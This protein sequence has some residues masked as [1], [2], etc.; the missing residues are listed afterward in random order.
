MNER[1]AD[2]KKLL[3]ERVLVLDGAMGTMIQKHNLQEEDFRGKEFAAHSLPQTGNN[4]LLSLSQPL[5]IKEIHKEYIRAGADIIE[6]NTFNAQRIS[7]ADYGMEDQVYRINK[8]AAEIACAAIDEIASEFPDKVFYVAGSMGPTNKTASMSPEVN[9]P[10]YREVSFDTLAD[11]Y[12]E[13]ALGLY[14]GGVDIFLVETVF[15]TLNAKAA[16]FAIDKVLADKDDERYIMVSGTITDASGRTLSGQTPEAFLTSLSHAKLLSIGLNCAL[17]AHDM[18]PWLRDLSR[19]S[20]FFISAHPNAGLPNQFGEYDQDPEAMGSETDK[21]LAERQVN[22]I[23]GCCGTQPGHIHRIAEAA[24]KSQPR[25]PKAPDYQ[26]KLSGL[27]PLLVYAGSNFVNIGERTNVAGSRKFARLIRE[28]NYEEALSIAIQQ[29]NNGAQVIDV[30]MDDAMLDAVAA[31]KRF[32][33]LLAAEPDAAKVPVMIDSS[34]WEV[35]EAGLKCVQGKAIVNSISLKDGE[36]AFIEKAAKIKKY[37][38]A[39]VVMAFDENGQAAS[40]DEKI[41][42]CK[43]SYDILVQ[44]EFPSEDIIM[45]PNILTIGTGMDEHNNYAV[46]FIKC[47]S[48]IKENL[49]HAKVSG[50]VSN[51]SFSFRGN[52]S[53][54][55][56]IHSVFLYHAIKAGL[57]MAIINPALLQVYDDIPNDLLELTEDLVLNKRKDATERL[58]MY[59][60][61]HNDKHQKAQKEEEWRHFEVIDRLK[62]ALVKGIGDYIIEDCE[63]VRKN[64]SR[65]LDVIEG[66]LMDGMTIVGNLFG[67]GRMFLPQVVKSARVMKKAVAYLQPFIE[68]ENAGLPSSA[69][70]ILM[71]TVKGDVH[72]IGKN[73]VGVIMACNNYEVVDLGVMVPVDTII[74][75]ARAHQVD[76]IGLS[77]LITPSLE[78]MTHV[79]ERMNAEGFD[80]PLIIGGA[81]TSEIHT[82]V[83]ISEKYPPGVIHVRDAS[84][85]VGVLSKLIDP[86]KK[87]EF[88]AQINERYLKLQVKHKQKKPNTSYISLN[89]ARNNDFKTDWSKMNLSKPNQ[90]GQ[91][92]IEN[93]NIEE[94]IPYIDWTFFFHAWKLNG[95]YPAILEDAVK[96]AEAKKLLEDA[97]DMLELIVRN[98]WLMAKASY[99]IFPAKRMG[100]DVEIECNSEKIKFHFLRNQENKEKGTPNWSLADFIAP[101]LE[102]QIDY[103]GLFAVSAGF[104]ADDAAQAF[105]Q[106]LDDYSEI[107][108]K[109]LADR[110]AEAFAEFLHERIRKEIWAYSPDEQLTVNQMLKGEFRGIRPAP[111]YPAC[112]DHS[113]KQIIFNTLKANDIGIMLTDNYSMIPAASVSGYYFNHPGARYFNLGKIDEDQLSDY[114]QRKGI[115][116]EECAMLLNTNI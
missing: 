14:D 23:G 73:I 61:S 93:Q 88:L 113:E 80:I 76:V 37:G 100:D 83:K 59:A 78:E 51:L 13:Q 43:R 60:D 66:P 97:Q 57:D 69:G 1:K 101:E 33:N 32:L 87:K 106:N 70:K 42:V 46:D 109:I 45:D 5:I 114:A 89:A 110:L 98:K 99:G 82:A 24:A 102:D 28:E 96:G 107:M 84:K 68:E 9:D 34:K 95:R 25:I 36:K 67:D 15:D 16:L 56:A 112:P 7:M 65:T 85:S 62:H 29:V 63:E 49:P 115:S 77:G 26:L 64:Y 54:R 71:A 12:Y 116:I 39:V 75:E 8:S 50:G 74:K 108:L 31:M 4:D 90:I 41:R 3:K 11:A 10:G 72:D 40:Y 20:S 103:L 58:L 35:I 91:Y 92:F 27:E 6:T 17:G 81:T 79:A 55:E 111:G 18:L 22:I 30:C 48:W 53:V 19:K 52:Q 44:N 94:L 105:R 86:Q 21:F 2:I 38:A 47:C 104:G